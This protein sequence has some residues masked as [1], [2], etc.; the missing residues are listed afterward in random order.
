M[1]NYIRKKKIESAWKRNHREHI[2]AG[3]DKVEYVLILFNYDHLSKIMPIARELLKQKKKVYLWTTVDVKGH[4]SKIYDSSGQGIRVITPEDKSKMRIV[5]GATLKEFKS[6]RH[7]L[8]L[9]FTTE[10]DEV[11]FY[12]ILNSIC[13][14]NIGFR[15]SIYKVYDFIYL[16]NEEQEPIDAFMDVKNYLESYARKSK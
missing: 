7:D 3:L 15:E 14:F 6:L 5:T 2:F 1:F 11:L 13:K 4:S 16:K 10:H 8:I 9:D 12:L